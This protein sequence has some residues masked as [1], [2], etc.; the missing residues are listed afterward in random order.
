MIQEAQ[1]QLEQAQIATVTT[2]NLRCPAVRLGDSAQIHDPQVGE[3][4]G[5]HQAQDPRGVA[6]MAFVQLKPSAF[7]VGKEGFNVRAFVILSR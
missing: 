5:Q 1:P 6:H 2:M 7:L 3:A 4:G